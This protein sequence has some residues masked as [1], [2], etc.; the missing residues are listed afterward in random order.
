MTGGVQLGIA[1]DVTHR[2]SGLGPEKL[3]QRA[4]VMII[5]CSDVALSGVIL[6]WVR[7][8]KTWVA[9]FAR[10]VMRAK[11]VRI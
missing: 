2:M 4:I 1:R 6:L 8:Q 11:M 5:V 3:S 9:F 7:L 10:T